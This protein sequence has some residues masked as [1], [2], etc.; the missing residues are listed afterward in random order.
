MINNNHQ[1]SDCAFGERLVS[2]LYGESSGAESFEVEK[3]LKNCEACADEFAAFSGLH[4]AID[5]W[6]TT[7]FAPLATPLIEIPYETKTEVVKSSWLSG[8]RQIFALSPA[9]SLATAS[10][11]VLVIC[12]GIVWLALNARQIDDVAENEKNKNQSISPAAQQTPPATTAK[13]DPV[14]K[15]DE[16]VNPINEPKAPAIENAVDQDS[17][18]TR[19]VKIVNNPRPSSKSDNAPKTTPKRNTKNQP[20]PKLMTDESEEDDSLR[21]A[22]LFEEI[23]TDE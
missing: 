11:A 14:K 13:N 12:T 8:L 3:H 22:E 18:N 15:A 7:E 5:D 6:K 2:Y 21:L 23:G 10:A 20:A 9:W 19:A 4:F 17:K 1:N 16:Q